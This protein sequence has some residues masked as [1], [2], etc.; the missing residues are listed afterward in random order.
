[1]SDIL[2]QPIPRTAAEYKA[3]IAQVLAAMQ[4]RNE[5]DDGPDS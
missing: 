5:P 1:M 4:R 2:P 3:A